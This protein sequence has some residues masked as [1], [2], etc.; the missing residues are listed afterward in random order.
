MSTLKHNKEK[1]TSIHFESND[2]SIEINEKDSEGIG[3][4]IIE[5]ALSIPNVKVNRTEFLSN[6]LKDKVTPDVL[7]KAI[8]YGTAEA[9]I[10]LKII[11]ESAKKC[12][13]STK[14]ISTAESAATGVLGGPVGISTGIVADITQFYGNLIILIQKLVY[15][16]GMKD[17]NSIDEIRNNNKNAAAFILLFI[18]AASGVRGLD[19]VI[20][21]ITKSMTKQ[22]AKQAGKLI[23]FAKP[24][25]YSIAK[26]VA[27]SIGKGIS[28]KGFAKV[29]SKA[30]PVIGA[31][32]S[33]GLN[34]VTFTPMANR[35]NNILEESYNISLD[36]TL[37]N[38]VEEM[39]K[40]NDLNLEELSELDELKQE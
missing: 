4:W 33:A 23:L 7:E 27:K 38:K 22:Y 14:K 5:K 24:A 3:F 17:L 8:K 31:G 12:I 26:K 30:V 1:A 6:V 21:V 37:L 25:F 29:A 15:L 13:S 16:Y 36:E 9:G 35:L 39:V 2:E 11:R 40:D 34:W 18:G 20:K 10:P 19:Q 32:I 28:K